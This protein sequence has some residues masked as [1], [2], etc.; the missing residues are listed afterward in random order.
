MSFNLTKGDSELEIA[1]PASWRRRGVAF[2]RWFVH[3]KVL[4]RIGQ[5]R[6]ENLEFDGRKSKCRQGFRKRKKVPNW[7]WPKLPPKRRCS[8]RRGG[9]Q[10]RRRVR[11]AA[12]SPSSSRALHECQLH[13][14]NEVQGV[15]SWALRLRSSHH[16]PPPMHG[17]RDG[18]R[19]ALTWRKRLSML[20]LLTG[21]F[22][23]GFYGRGFVLNMR[24]VMAFPTR[25]RGNKKDTSCWEL[26][27][28]HQSLPPKTLAKVWDRG[29]CLICH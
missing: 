23:S 29:S 18:I 6:R 1:H 13:H 22:N 7:W 11:W 17:P 24:G 21:I 10:G 3:S 4:K 5:R 26:S 28:S 14:I 19:H 16:E 12:P 8:G 2:D 25:Q 15:P 9:R 20:M 27:T